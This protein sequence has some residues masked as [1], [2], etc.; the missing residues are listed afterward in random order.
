MKCVF[1]HFMGFFFKIIL[2]R[3]IR[4]TT[5]IATVVAIPAATF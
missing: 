1:I 2:F 3:I 4:P 5:V